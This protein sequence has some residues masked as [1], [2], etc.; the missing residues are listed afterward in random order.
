MVRERVPVTD[1]NG[2]Q[3]HVWKGKKNQIKR[4]GPLDVLTRSYRA[5]IQGFH[6]RSDSVK[7]IKEEQA[8][9][10]KKQAELFY[11]YIEKGKV[12]QWK[13]A[14]YTS[15]G[16]KHIS[17]GRYN[18]PEK[19]AATY[20]AMIDI[21]TEL[22]E[23]VR[24]SIFA[25]SYKKQGGLRGLLNRAGIV[26]YDFKLNIRDQ[27]GY[28][29]A[30]QAALRDADEGLVSYRLISAM[31]DLNSTFSYVVGDSMEEDVA[32][33]IAISRSA[34]VD[35]PHDNPFLS[36]NFHPDSVTR[37]YLD[38]LNMEAADLGYTESERL[39]LGFMMAGQM[40]RTGRSYGNMAMRM[41]T[42]VSRKTPVSE[43][44]NE[45]SLTW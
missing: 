22:P 26:G 10:P 14:S 19:A 28:R 18:L 37:D 41:M 21:G 36:N 13:N 31:K 16:K 29:A 43:I 7:L 6:S 4:Q 24:K 3:T 1:K 34:A 33:A 39:A 23:E 30:A 44:K 38:E 17:K 12:H 5:K 11:D 8:V 42:L 15:G 35:L 40:A 32:E 9:I 20:I 25:M 45:M 2:K 27:E